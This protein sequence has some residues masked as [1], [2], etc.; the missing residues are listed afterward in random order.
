[1]SNSGIQLDKAGTFK[2][3]PFDWSVQPSKENKGVAISVGFIIEEEYDFESKTWLS[4]RE[5]D[6]YTTRGWWYIVKKD[7]G[8]NKSAIQQLVES[9]GWD[10]NLN[11]I[12]GEPPDLLVQIVVKKENYKGE[13]RYKVGWM[14]PEDAVPGAFGASEAEVVDLQSRFGSMLK[15][16]AGVKRATPKAP[17]ATPAAASTPPPVTA[18]TPI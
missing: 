12:L 17:P 16:V 5:T 18:D 1:M 8:I 3:R 6:A 7:G 14:S 13:D 10:A 2:A 4:W 9:M 11:S 15:A